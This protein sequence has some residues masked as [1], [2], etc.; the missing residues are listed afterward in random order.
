MEAVEL[1]QRLSDRLT[2]QDA[3]ALIANGL[4]S[5]PMIKTMAIMFIMRSSEEDLERYRG[6]LLSCL[7]CIESGDPERLE[8]ILVNA[9]LPSQMIELLKSYVTRKAS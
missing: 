5:N 6:V 4:S 7:D 8:S 9:G 3:V 1:R 2:K